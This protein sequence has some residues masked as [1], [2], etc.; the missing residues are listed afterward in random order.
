MKRVRLSQGYMALVDD[1]DYLLVSE[2]LW[3]VDK[4]EK[5]IY[6]IRKVRRDGRR[7]KCYMH[8]FIVQPP[9]GLVVDHINGNGLDNRRSNLR[10]CTI[11][12]NLRNMSKPSRSN[13][14]SRYKGVC[15]LAPDRVWRASICYERKTIYIGRFQTEE[16][17]AVAYN[18]KAKELFGAFAN[19]N[20]V[21][22]A[23]VAVV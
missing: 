14:S 9:M 3:H 4:F 18:H 11:K 6:A 16:E 8:R 2:H 22:S 1:E 10:I 15:F 7:Q 12:E 23:A 17:A 20:E 5:K 13:A 19:L 21:H